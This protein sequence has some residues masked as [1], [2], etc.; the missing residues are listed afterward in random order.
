MMNS[1]EMKKNEK[2]RRTWDIRNGKNNLNPNN[3]K[4]ELYPIIKKIS[5]CSKLYL[6]K[7]DLK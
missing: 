1:R 7:E 6:Q 2:V 3:R 4:Y 5:C